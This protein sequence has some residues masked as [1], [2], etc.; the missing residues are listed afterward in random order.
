MP[1]SAAGS[2]AACGRTIVSYDW[3][4]TGL[5]TPPNQATATFIAPTSGSVTA[6]VT[7]TD[8]AGR[9]GF[10][11]R[12]ADVE[13]RHDHGAVERR[14]ERMPRVRRAAAT[15]DR[16]R[17]SGDSHAGG[18]SIADVL[19]NG[20]ELGEYGGELECERCRRRWLHDG[21][22]TTAGVFTAPATVAAA[23]VVTV[24]AAWSGDSTR[25]G[26]AQITVNPVA[27]AQAP[28]LGR[29]RRRLR[30]RRARGAR[31][32]GPAATAARTAPLASARE[33][34]PP[35]VAMAE[36]RAYTTTCG[37]RRF[38]GSMQSS[39]SWRTDRCGRSPS[40]VRC[41]PASRRRAPRIS[42]RS[43]LTAPPRT[44]WPTNGG[45]LYNQRYSPLNAINAGE[46]R[47]AERRVARAAERLG[48]GAAVLRRSAA[49][50]LRRHRLCEHGR[51]RRVRAVARRRQDSLAVRGSPRPEADFGLLRLDE[52]RCRARRGQG[53]RRP[54]RRQA[55]R[56]RSALRQG[57]MDARKRSAGRTTSRSR[58]RRCMS[59]ARS[60]S[61]SRA[62]IAARA[63]A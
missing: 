29:W 37:P 62:R 61:A 42:Q 35:Q 17:G 21:T 10:R 59:T 43:T 4:G 49:H 7:V 47:H 63:D 50:R 45:N 44:G 31:G 34:A 25:T 3:A 23:L 28:S 13:H 26:S 36:G 38:G 52:S 9:T 22:I 51:R 19:R 56:A 41:T 24:T 14:H 30:P 5:I 48:R 55:R 40:C 32:V 8:D 27:G 6:T 46:R 18:R 53:V 2:A 15:G 39:L 33:Q 12:R 1:L 57:R 54:A 20:S 60:S 58:P 11:R 16:H